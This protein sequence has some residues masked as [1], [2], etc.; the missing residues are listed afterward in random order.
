[1]VVGG[2]GGDGHSLISRTIR[3]AVACSTVNVSC[4]LL[5]MR[6]LALRAYE[7]VVWS[8]WQSPP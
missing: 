1:M 4:R 8:L 7:Q 5:Y 2:G 3:F 6:I